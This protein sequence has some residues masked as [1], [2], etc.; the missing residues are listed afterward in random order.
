MFYKEDEVSVILG[1]FY[2][3]FVVVLQDL[4]LSLKIYKDSYSIVQITLLPQKN[5]LSRIKWN[6]FCSGLFISVCGF[7]R[8]DGDNSEQVKDF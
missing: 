7:E 3:I 5:F 4:N 8:P 2:G 1:I 6:H